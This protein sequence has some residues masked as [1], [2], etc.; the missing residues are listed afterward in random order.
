MTDEHSEQ[1]ETPQ[2]REPDALEPDWFLQALVNIA[3]AG[4]VE[5]GMTL[6]VGG[7]LVSGKMIGGA[8]Y[9]EGFANDFAGGFPDHAVAEDI[10]KSFS[11]YGEIYKT[12]AGNPPVPA[13]VHLMEARFFNT[14]G[15]PIPGN[16]GVWWRGRLSE[17]S[18]FMLGTLTSG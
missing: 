11:E 12:D 8:R 17:V 5:I 16:R 2:A 9:F 4:D 10:R 14:A 13:Y 18:G 1:P 3:N 7:F 6:L 15:N